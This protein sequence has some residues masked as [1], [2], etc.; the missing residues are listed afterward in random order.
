MTE[1]PKTTG[2]R[3]AI[4]LTGADRQKAIDLYIAGMR[5]SKI[6][7]TLGVSIN[8]IRFLTES[9]LPD[10]VQARIERKQK[11]RSQVIGD[12][13][14]QLCRK[15]GINVGRTKLYS[16]LSKLTEDDAV[17]ILLAIQRHGGGQAF[18]D[19]LLRN[20]L[21]RAESRPR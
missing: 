10:A 7:A 4:W 20:Y 5:R 2:K 16:S 11:R 12:N 13:I 21:S 19:L 15:I 9:R 18:L 1:K 6:A 17:E 8:R 3:E 14:R